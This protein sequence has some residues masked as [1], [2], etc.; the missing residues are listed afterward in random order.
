MAGPVDRIM[1][2]RHLE[3][4]SPAQIKRYLHAVPFEPFTVVLAN[5]MRYPVLNPDVLTVTLQ[6]R[7]IHEDVTGPTTE[8]N[9]VLVAEI[10]RERASAKGE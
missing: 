6:N 8:I 7:V 2:G 10:V 1:P 9:P 5:G 4:V 3:F